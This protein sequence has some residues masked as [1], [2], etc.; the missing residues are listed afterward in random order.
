MWCKVL[1]TCL[2]SHQTQLVKS[3]LTNCTVNTAT[4]HQPLFQDSKSTLTNCTLNNF[5]TNSLLNSL[6]L[7]LKTRWK[8]QGGHSFP[9]DHNPVSSQQITIKI[10]EKIR[11]KT[12]V[13]GNV[14]FNCRTIF[15]SPGNT[16]GGWIIKITEEMRSKE[17]CVSGMVE[18]L[19]NHT[20][21]VFL[22]K[23][24][25]LFFSCQLFGDWASLPVHYL[26]DTICVGGERLYVNICFERVIQQ[27]R[28]RTIIP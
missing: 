13:S 28:D 19:T 9:L 20:N 23:V 22:N 24:A 10:T 18:T 4:H 2:D 11:S 8:E 27:S 26:H 16:T 15:Q 25:G 7:P 14:F 21:S 1:Q 3:K 17:T 5:T 6:W 12:R